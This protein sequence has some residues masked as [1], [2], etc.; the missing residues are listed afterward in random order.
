[1]VYAGFGYTLILVPGRRTGTKPFNGRERKHMC[2][3]FALI[4]SITPRLALVLIFFFTDWIQL[5]FNN[6]LWPVIGFVVLPYTT[7]AYMAAMLL[8]HHMLS[9]LWLLV[10]LVAVLLDASHW[11]GGHRTYQE[12]WRRE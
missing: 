4:G 9:G 5:A 11:S 7:L 8:N 12:R 3:L 2:C 10:V 1:L 6:L